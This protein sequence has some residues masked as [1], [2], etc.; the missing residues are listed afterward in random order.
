MTL[1]RKESRDSQ[2]FVIRCDY[3]DVILYPLDINEEVILLLLAETQPL[4]LYH[5][6]STCKTVTLVVYVCDFVYYIL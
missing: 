4:Y 3:V 5:V 2:V 6:S 1:L